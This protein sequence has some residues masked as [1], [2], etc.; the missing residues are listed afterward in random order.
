MKDISKHYDMLT[1]QERLVLTVE[2]QARGDTAESDRLMKGCPRKRYIMNDV[3]FSM[4]FSRLRTFALTSLA[5]S[6]QALAKANMAIGV[7]V[8]GRDEMWEL[9]AFY[10]VNQLSFQEAWKRFCNSIGLD[11]DKVF[12]AFGL[13]VADLQQP[14]LDESIV[15]DEEAVAIL[16]EGM[17]EAWGSA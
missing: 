16:F 1:P 14:P 17:R 12:A 5:S 2:A 8:S 13:D 10:K 3:N 6:Y 15:A 7:I 9:Y 4:A 11:G